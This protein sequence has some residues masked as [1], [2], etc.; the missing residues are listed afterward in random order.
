MESRAYQHMYLAIEGDT[1]QG[2][3]KLNQYYGMSMSIAMVFPKCPISL[4]DTH[5]DDQH[6][7][8][9]NYL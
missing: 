4:F 8:V 1:I 7:L 3:H 2:I 6:I 9:L 5:L